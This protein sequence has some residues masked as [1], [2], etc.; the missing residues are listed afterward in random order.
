MFVKPQSIGSVAYMYR[1]LPNLK[2]M[3][4]DDAGAI[5]AINQFGLVDRLH[6]IGFNWVDTNKSFEE[7]FYLQHGIS[8]DKKW[9]SFRC[10]RDSHI[11]NAVYQHFNIKE[12]Y[13]F[14]HDDHRYKLD[15]TRISPK[16]RIIRPEVGLVN[17]IFAY[18]LV[19]ERAKEIHCME[20]CFGFMAD[21]MGLNKELFMHRYSRTPPKFEIPLY[22]NVKEILT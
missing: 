17:T 5:G 2:F 16:I 8:L 21:N 20:S 3:E 7:N 22:R 14:V 9:D 19:M 13:I 4:C 11:E 1:D 15:E 10:D 18:A 12:P 6:L